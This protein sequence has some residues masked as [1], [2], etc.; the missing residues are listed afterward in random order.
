VSVQEKNDFS[1]KLL[2]LKG[3]SQMKAKALLVSI[4]LMVLSCG[5]KQKSLPEARVSGVE[6]CHR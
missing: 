1:D 6:S 5:G 4:A 3:E 2:G